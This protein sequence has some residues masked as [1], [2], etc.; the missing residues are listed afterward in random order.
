MAEFSHF[1]QAGASRMVNVGAKPVTVRTARASAQ[2]QMLPTTLDQLRRRQMVK[3]DVLEVAR[4]AGI[5]G[6]KRTADLVPLCHP[7]PLDAV[8]IA[9]AFPGSSTLLITAQVQA[10]ARTGVE[11]EA[12]MAVSVAALTVYDMCKAMDRGMAI[13]QI[14]LEEKDGGRSGHFVRQP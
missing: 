4:L 14:Q 11:M 1:D 10:T 7:V 3:G 5:M 8:E 6:S 12:L 2:M 13:Q 9:F